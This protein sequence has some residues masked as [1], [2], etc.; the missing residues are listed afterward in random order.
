MTAT[1]VAC[2]PPD[3][4]NLETTRETIPPACERSLAKTCP[5]E[6]ISLDA[7]CLTGSS[8]AE[9]DRAILNREV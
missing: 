1:P 9:N 2:R 3:N 7:K 5:R 4:G 6:H 8:P